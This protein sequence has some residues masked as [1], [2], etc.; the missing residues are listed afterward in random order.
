MKE[1]YRFF[2]YFSPKMG[3]DISNPIFSGKIRNNFI[4]LLSAE[5]ADCVVNDNSQ[6]SVR[7]QVLQN[8]AFPEQWIYLLYHIQ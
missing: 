5:T 8:Y 1:E 2:A 3:F 4:N 6:M 7:K